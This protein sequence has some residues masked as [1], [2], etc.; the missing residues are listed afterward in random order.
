[1]IFGLFKKKEVKKEEPKKKPRKQKRFKIIVKLKD[2][3]ELSVTDIKPSE[4]KKTY[5]EFQAD[6]KN[7]SDFLEVNNGIIPKKEIKYIIHQEYTI[8]K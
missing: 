6:M 8:L 7:K 4:I 1:M 3:E 2:G 5:K